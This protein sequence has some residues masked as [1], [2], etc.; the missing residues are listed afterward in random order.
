MADDSITRRDHE[1]KF[2]R[3]TTVSHVI[4]LKPFQGY[5][6]EVDDEHFHLDSAV[7]LPNYGTSAAQDA[8]EGPTLGLAVLAECLR[9]AKDNPNQTVLIAGH[10]DTS[11]QDAY[12]LTL[13]KKRANA[14]LHAIMGERDQWVAI[15]NAQHK[16]EDYQLIFKWVASIYGWDCDPG[17]VDNVQGPKTTQATMNFQERYNLEF[18]GSI[19]K[20]GVVGVQ[21]WGAIFDVY[22]DMLTNLLETDDDG[23]AALRSGVKFLGP[24]VVGCGENFPIEAPRKNNYRSRVNRRVEILFFDPGQEPKLD[25]HPGDACK[26]ILCETYNPKMYKFKHL[27]VSP[28]APKPNRVFLKLVYLDPEKNEKVFPPDFPVTIEYPDGTTQIEKVAADGKLFFGAQRKGSFVVRFESGATEY[29]ATAPPGSADPKPDRLGADA[30]LKNLHQLNFRFFSVPLKW[31]LKESDWKVEGAKQYD[32]SNFNFLIPGRFGRTIATAAAPG[33]MTLNPHW[34]FVRFEFFDRYFGHSDHNHK[35][36]NTPATLIDGFRTNP[37]AATPDVRSHWTIQDDD[38]T[39]SVHAVPWILQ[40]KPDRTAE[41]KPDKDIQFGFQTDAGT[42][43]ISDS[44]ASRKIDAVTDANK[45]KPSA[46]RLKLYDLPAKWKSANYYTRFPDGTGEYFDKASTFEAKIKGSDDPAAPLIFS[47]DDIVLTDA[48]NQPLAVQATDRVA[49]F[50]HKFVKAAEAGKTSDIGLYN[51]DDGNNTSYYTKLDLKSKNYINDYPNWTRLVVAQENMFD[52]FSERTPDGATV[53]GARAAVRWVDSPGTGPPAAPPGAANPPTN[54]ARGVRTDKPFFSIQPFFE[55]RWNQT[56]LKFTGPNTTQQGFGRYDMALLRC[57]DHDGDTELIANMHYFRFLLRFNPAVPPPPPPPTP[58]PPVAVSP[59]HPPTA[60]ATIQANRGQYADNLSKNI[61]N[62]WNGND[63]QNS[64]RAE[65]L[66]QKATDK[67]KAQV[68]LFIQPVATNTRAHFTLD[69][70]RPGAGQLGG[71]AW[72]FALNGTGELGENSSAMEQQHSHN[73]YTAAHETGHGDSFPDEYNERWNAF[74]Y[75]ELSYQCNTPGDPF[76]LDDKLITNAATVAATVKDNGMMIGNVNPRNRY[77][78]HCAEFSRLATNVAFKVKYDT[79]EDYKLP[80]FNGNAPGPPHQ[81]YVWWPINQ[82]ID[83]TQGTRGMY[84][85]LL[86]AFGKDRYSQ[87]ILSKGPFDGMLV[88]MVKIEYTLYSNAVNNIT[89]ILPKIS[90]VI[91]QRFNNK[92]YATGTV[93]SGSAQEWTFQKCLILFSPRF[94]VSNNNSA[95]A[96][97]GGLRAN[98]GNHFTAQVN[99]VNPPNTRWTANRA[100][101]LEFTTAAN[102]PAGAPQPW[103]VQLKNAFADKFCAMIGLAENA[104]AVNAAALMPIVQTVITTGAGVHDL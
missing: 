62:R 41:E 10:A 8:A 50:Y 83:Q 61:I 100:L 35:R 95:A 22:M 70:V 94:L 4:H 9:H 23:V 30:D 57:C 25:C 79:Y 80:P 36:I 84:D 65:L 90:E 68:L 5:V 86:Y 17:K 43:V 98:V 85:S 82:S 77:F 89:L 48:A 7:L 46:D 91:R 33:K 103:D 66:P 76:E 55:E 38:V 71:R 20:N 73:S 78:W 27:P 19:A 63:V 47:L 15:S 2:E 56:N 6:L 92:W 75:T 26:A 29:I 16:T 11:G 1:Q 21:T 3:P 31:T 104:G 49:I 60:A 37:P 88:V 101:T 14:V 69:I 39:K 87:D 74:S 96:A 58:P 28:S 42:F 40:F 51:F 93:N 45:L 13:S 67:I 54:M 97:Y 12:N 52:T 81:S 64:K 32:D 18:D 72:M 102:F 24:K 99:N 44:A 34:H 53:V 59:F